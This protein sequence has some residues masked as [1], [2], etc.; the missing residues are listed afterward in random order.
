MICL[1]LLSSVLWSVKQYEIDTIFILE[2]WDIMGTDII[3]SVAVKHCI[4]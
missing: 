1:R 4:L 3:S 2:I